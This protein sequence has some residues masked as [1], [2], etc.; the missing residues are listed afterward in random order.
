RTLLGALAWSHE[1]LAPELRAFFARL[2]LFRGSFALEAAEAVC[3]EPLALDRLS[4]LHECSLVATED[5]PSETRFRMLETIR[6]F[7][8]RQLEPDERARLQARHAEHALEVA[9]RASAALRGPEQAATLDRLALDFENLRAAIA[10]ALEA[11]PETALGVAEPLARFC[12]MR[13]RLPEGRAL[14]EAALAAAPAPSALRA[15]AL[16]VL[17]GL[18]L[19]QGDDA[20]AARD[21][22]ETVA[23]ARSLGARKIVAGGLHNLAILRHRKGELAA[24]RAAFEEAVAT[25]RELGD[26]PALGVA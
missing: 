25:F 12:D 26:G 24:A 3:E 11:R 10:W 4:E 2:S 18:A 13:G 23:L 9:R 14:L 6:E 17:G 1:L 21:F 20:A 15:S 22:E 19:T 8:S 16:L 5:A 7:A